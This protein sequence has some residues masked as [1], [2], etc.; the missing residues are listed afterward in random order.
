MI[1]VLCLFFDSYPPHRDSIPDLTIHENGQSHSIVRRDSPEDQSRPQSHQ[2]NGHILPDNRH[3]PSENGASDSS[4]HQNIQFPPDI[5]FNQKRVP[6]ERPESHISNGYVATDRIRETRSSSS[7]DIRTP[8]SY[9]LDRH[10]SKDDRFPV[11][12]QHKQIP[13]EQERTHHTTKEKE[14]EKH[15]NSIQGKRMTENNHFQKFLLSNQRNR[16]S[17]SS[18]GDQRYS[19]Q[20][21]INQRPES[22]T[23]EERHRTRLATYPESDSEVDDLMRVPTVSFLLTEKGELMEAHPGG[24]QRSLRMKPS[25]GILGSVKDD[26][27]LPM[28]PIA[29]TSKGFKSSLKARSTD[30]IAQEPRKQPSSENGGSPTSIPNDREK[31]R[32]LFGGRPKLSSN[33]SLDVEAGRAVRLDEMS[34]TPSPDASHWRYDSRD[35][36]FLREERQLP[37]SPSDPGF[38]RHTA[39]NWPDSAPRTPSPSL[40]GSLRTEASRTQNWSSSRPTT[41]SQTWSESAVH[42]PTSSQR[43]QWSPHQSSDEGDYAMATP[44]QMPSKPPVPEH[45]QEKTVQKSQKGKQKQKGDEEEDEE[46]D[47]DVPSGGSLTT[48]LLQKWLKQRKNKIGKSKSNP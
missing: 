32:Y 18:S 41:P 5:K 7:Q 46:E 26:K 16:S 29:S 24:G 12:V 36:N 10:T 45:R 39:H 22:I 43:V 38:V 44:P 1:Y 14:Q 21:E 33:R 34:N 47:A 48:Q 6:R 11:D 3:S 28:M 25:R 35:A 40:A 27:L 4:F 19:E 13:P 15:D 8:E 17:S 20:S 31:E 2:H 30:A 37:S 23:P 42:S 9:R